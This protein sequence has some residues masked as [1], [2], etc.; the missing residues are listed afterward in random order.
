[1]LHRL[2]EQIMFPFVLLTCP[3]YFWLRVSFIHFYFMIAEN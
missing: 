2:K 3:F 1:M